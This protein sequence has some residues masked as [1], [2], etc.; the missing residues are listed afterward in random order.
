MT[1]PVITGPEPSAAAAA[2]E[3]PYDHTPALMGHSRSSSPALHHRMHLML[4]LVTFVIGCVALGLGFVVDAHLAA[5]TLGLLGVALGLW[6]QLTSE[7]TGQRWFD[8][9]GLGAAAV[10]MGLGFG[11]G[12]F[13]F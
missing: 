10:G 12:G 2:P 7:S 5:T 13:G 1:E 9:I 6:C 4:T 11:H 8:V 3:R